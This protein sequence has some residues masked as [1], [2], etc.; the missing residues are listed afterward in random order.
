MHTGTTPR[1]PAPGGYDVTDSHFGAF[2]EALPPAPQA[3]SPG[4]RLVAMA[5]ERCTVD[6]YT[7]WPAY[8][9]QLERIVVGLLDTP[10]PGGRQ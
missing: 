7:S 10:A 2:A 1:R 8:A 5:R 9:E 3:D 6:G 4:Q